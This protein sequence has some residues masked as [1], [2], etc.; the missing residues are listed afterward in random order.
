MGEGRGEPLWLLPID[1]LLGSCP[2]QPATLVNA[3]SV[4][5]LNILGLAS[6]G[7]TLQI[8]ASAADEHAGMTAKSAPVK[9]DYMPQTMQQHA[10]MRG[11][12][13]GHLEPREVD[14]TIS[15]F[16]SS[17]AVQGPHDICDPRLPACSGPQAMQALQLTHLDLATTHAR[18]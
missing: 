11:I 12:D 16:R 9:P 15:V 10:A 8:G 17:P 13:V 18:V 1:G 4:V 5:S 14:A 6:P 2:A 7:S 3:S